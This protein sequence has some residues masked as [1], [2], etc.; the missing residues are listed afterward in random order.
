[1]ITEQQAPAIHGTLIGNKLKARAQK[2]SGVSQEK[3]DA[4]KPAVVAA[5]KSNQN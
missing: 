5:A 2:R 3:L 1:L 4:A